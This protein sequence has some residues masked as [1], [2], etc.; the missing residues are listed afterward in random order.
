[1]ANFGVLQ[2]GKFTSDG[3]AKTLNLRSD[4]DFITVYNFTNAMN[5]NGNDGVEFYWQ[6][7]M[8]NGSGMY[9]YLSGGTN[10]LNEGVL[11]AST[12][13]YVV[14]TTVSPLGAAYAITSS[15]DATR[16]VFTIPDTTAS[17]GLVAGDIVRIYGQSGQPNVNGYD[18]TI[19][20]VGANDFR[21]APALATTPGVV[22]AGGYFR[23]LNFDSIYYPRLRFIVDIDSSGTSTVVKCSIPSGYVAG[24]KVTV[25]VPQDAVS[26]TPVYGPMAA[27]IN[28][29]SGTVTSVN[30]AVGTQTVTLDIDS[31][32]F[33]A[34]TF[35][36][37]VQA[38]GALSKALLIPEGENSPY[39]YSNNINV[40]SDAVYNTG[41][42][43]VTLKG[44][45]SAPGGGNN[46]VM[47]WVAGKSYSVDN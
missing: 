3:N 12:G 38:A 26:G 17:V 41:Y 24:Q 21:W 39:A 35:P 4:I 33:G 32:S 44:G 19:D 36:D 22:G 31:S 7:G 47:Y 5:G 11:A 40:L 28:G 6:R 34:F 14:N 9:K 27:Y 13:F 1:M 15:T 29:L 10:A 45:A 20:A 16:P 2:Q 37:A 30:D 46:D 18:V 23:K 42:L 25:V 8:G 43:G